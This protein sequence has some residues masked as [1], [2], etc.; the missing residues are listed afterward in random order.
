MNKT[1]EI[2]R[3]EE[4]QARLQDESNWPR[5][6]NRDSDGIFRNA[7]AN[8]LTARSIMMVAEEIRRDFV[9]TALPYIAFMTGRDLRTSE[10]LGETKLDRLW[11]MVSER[12]SARWWIDTIGCG[13]EAPMTWLL[14]GNNAK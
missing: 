11:Q 1:K 5:L 2:E 4:I 7:I 14:E 10:T 8:H 9:E 6:A 12:R 3:L 13:D